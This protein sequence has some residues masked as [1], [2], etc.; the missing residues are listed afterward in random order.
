M[1]IR[2]R[3]HSET[4][5]WKTEGY[6]MFPWHFGVGRADSLTHQPKQRVAR[7]LVIA[8]VRSRHS[9]HVI[10]VGIAH[11]KSSFDGA[12]SEKIGS[13]GEVTGAV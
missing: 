11:E 5:R 6:L 7:G 3:C 2:W 12:L 4:W 1:A 13:K 9:L 8:D 10:A